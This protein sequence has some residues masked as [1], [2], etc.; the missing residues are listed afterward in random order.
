MVGAGFFPGQET[1]HLAG[2]CRFLQQGAR[3]LVLFLAA[4]HNDFFLAVAAQFEMAPLPIADQQAG[5]GGGQ[6]SP[7]PAQQDD[8][9][10]VA[11][12]I[13]EVGQGRDQ[14]RTESDAFQQ[15]A[16]AVGAVVASPKIEAE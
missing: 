14:Y 1:H 6:Q 9:F 4:H 3:P 16:E 13:G 2:D 12:G 11:V 10:R 5:Q 7:A 15:V 8:G